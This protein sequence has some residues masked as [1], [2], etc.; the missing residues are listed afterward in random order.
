MYVNMYLGVQ[1]K[2][3]DLS[4]ENKLAVMLSDCA[5]RLPVFF[6]RTGTAAPPDKLAVIFDNKLTD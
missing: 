1:T 3:L 4:K 6:H 5:W 2:N